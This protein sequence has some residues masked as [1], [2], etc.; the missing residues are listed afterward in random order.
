MNSIKERI[1]AYTART[2]KTRYEIAK[3]LGMSKTALY[4]KLNGQTEF[5]L[6]EGRQLASTLGCTLDELFISPF[7]SV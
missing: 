2:G 5:T 7:Q 4:S 3:E 6:D 1:G